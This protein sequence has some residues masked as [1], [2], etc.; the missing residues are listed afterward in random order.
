[1][2]IANGEAAVVENRRAF[3][4]ALHEAGAPLLVGTDSG[5][6]RTQPGVSLHKEIAQFVAAG[7][8]VREVLRIATE[9]ASRFLGAGDDIGR[10]DVGF[11]ADLLLVREN[12]ID[13]VT[14]LADPV[15]VLVR[16]QRVR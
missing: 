11:A 12:P 15:A 7:I 8:P 3:V 4:H 9:E 2:Q 6:G 13:D 5:I 1:A 10:V 16:G 14:S